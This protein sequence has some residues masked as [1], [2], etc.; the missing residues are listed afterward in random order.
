MDA[1]RSA[2]IRAVDS[3]PCT[4]RALAREAGVDH[5]LLTAIRDGRRSC[6]TATADKVASALERW[7]D[8]CQGAAHELRTAREASDD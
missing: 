2:L 3:A 7:G 5:K 1:L 8:L 6:T 4:I